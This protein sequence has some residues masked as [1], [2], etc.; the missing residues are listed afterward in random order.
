MKL[1]LIVRRTAPLVAVLAA[2]AALAACGSSSDD[3]STTSASSGG[4]GSDLTIAM[5]T[6]SASDAFYQKVREGAQ[7]EADR[8]GVTLDYQASNEFT[9]QDMIPVVDSLLTKRPDALAIAPAD[10]RAMTSTIRRFADADIPIVTFDSSV[11]D[12]PF[13]IVTQISS[14]NKL[15]GRLAADLLARE[16]DGRGQVATISTD[17]SNIVQY[18][19]ARGFNEEMAA[20]YPDVEIVAR[21]L[22]GADFPRAQTTAQTLMTKYSDLAGYFTT[23]SFCTEYA[24]QGLQGLHKQDSVAQIG[25]EAGPKEIDLLRSGVLRAVVAQNPAEQGRLAVRYAVMAARGETSGIPRT[26]AMD[27]V[28]ITADDVD[29]KQEFYYATKDSK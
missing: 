1:N 22:V 9:A 3:D 28:A 26:V 18:D 25:Y 17:T 20:R 27:P 11:T 8:L 24:A 14:N 6:G 29:S 4:G 21:E 15:G 16:I 19:R 23:C 10:P 5:A 12:P 7:E 2:S 13:D